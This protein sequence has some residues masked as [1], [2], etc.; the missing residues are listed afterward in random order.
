MLRSEP[1]FWESGNL[2][3][4][5]S[6]WVSRVR[7]G[8]VPG[9]EP[10]WQMQMWAWALGRDSL[11]LDWFPAFW[12]VLVALTIKQIQVIAIKWP[13]SV[14][15]LKETVICSYAHL[16][17]DIVAEQLWGHADMPLNP[18]WEIWPSTS[19]DLNLY[20]FTYRMG[21]LILSP[22]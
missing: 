21:M 8:K 16:T 11:S 14:F 10:L 6:N 22:Q 13:L 5:T 12:W 18:G 17:G 4:C 2:Q 7:A 9:M 3:V 20:F 15:I 1:K 19:I